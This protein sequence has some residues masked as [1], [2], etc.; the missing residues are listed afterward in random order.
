[1]TEA[2]YAKR[3]REMETYRASQTSQASAAVWTNPN[4]G[5]MTGAQKWEAFLNSP[6]QKA[7]VAAAAG[8]SQPVP[9]S[10]AP[11]SVASSGG[12]SGGGAGVVINIDYHPAVSLATEYELEAALEVAWRNLARKNG[13]VTT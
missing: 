8:Q 3:Q 6:A 11:A 4:A 12:V 1:M 2:N 5:E 7:A 13:V 9:R 10:S